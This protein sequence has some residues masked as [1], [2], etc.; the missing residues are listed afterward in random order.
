MGKSN[1]TIKV[2]ETTAC[3]TEQKQVVAAQ[4]HYTVSWLKKKKRKKPKVIS[5]ITFAGFFLVD[6]DRCEEQTLTP[7]FCNIQP[8]RCTKTEIPV[9][10]KFLAYQTV[11]GSA[12]LKTRKALN[13]P[14]ST[15]KIW[16]QWILLV[17]AF[18]I[19]DEIHVKPDFNE[20]RSCRFAVCADKLR[21]TF[22][23]EGIN[24]SLL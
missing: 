4:F 21:F 9:F 22:I 8:H 18:S 17:H 6:V 19:F 15:C 2:N 7:S 16:C 3:I 14:I 20:E 23:N 12:G 11:F 1:K 24:G 5:N 13:G 10:E